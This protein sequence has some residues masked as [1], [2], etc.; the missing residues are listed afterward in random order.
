[1][2]WEYSLRVR[3]KKVFL[4][5]LIQPWLPHFLH[6]R[7]S[8]WGVSCKNERQSS[9][10]LRCTLSLEFC[11]RLQIVILYNCICIIDVRSRGWATCVL[12]DPE[13]HFVEL[14]TLD[15]IPPLPRSTSEIANVKGRQDGLNMFPK[16]VDSSWQTEQTAEKWFEMKVRAYCNALGRSLQIILPCLS[17]LTLHMWLWPQN[18]RCMK[19]AGALLS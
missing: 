11:K 6:R 5:K 1:M 17:R 12:N 14:N 18:T 4:I 16:S 2:F 10:G 13:Q 7:D 19:N 3:A 9:Y 15:C 8:Q